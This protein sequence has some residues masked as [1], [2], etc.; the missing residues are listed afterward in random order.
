M[1]LIRLTTL[2]ALAM[3]VVLC[4]VTAPNVTRPRP[5]GDSSGAQTSAAHAIH[6]AAQT[7]LEVVGDSGAAQGKAELDTEGG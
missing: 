2:F 6:V 4:A 1:W 3:A 5:A 7:P